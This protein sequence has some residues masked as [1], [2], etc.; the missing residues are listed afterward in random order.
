MTRLLNTPII[1]RNAAPVASSCNDMLA[2][3]SKNET[4]RMP[5][6]FCA[7]A[8][9][10]QHAAST[11]PPTIVNARTCPII[12]LSLL[13]PHPHRRPAE[14]RSKTTLRLRTRSP[15]LLRLEDLRP[16]GFLDARIVHPEEA[17]A[18]GRVCVHSG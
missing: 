1:G 8:K 13:L 14:K 12:G 4:L 10:A 17:R 16:E 6:D 7:K 2:G 15:K 18:I 3:L 5:P 9:L 11:S